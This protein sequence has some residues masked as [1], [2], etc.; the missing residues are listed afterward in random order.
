MRII[1]LAPT[2]YNQ[3]TVPQAFGINRKT[4]KISKKRINLV[5]RLLGIL[6]KKTNETPKAVITVSTVPLGRGFQD[7]M[8]SYSFDE[9]N[10]KALERE[11][12]IVKPVEK[13]AQYVEDAM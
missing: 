9:A 4:P 2:N 7:A 10:L 13:T 12:S 3:K 11:L 8:D 1:S 5:D 6:G